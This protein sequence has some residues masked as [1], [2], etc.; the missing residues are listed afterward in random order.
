MGHWM[1]DVNGDDYYVG[2]KIE[3][4]TSS[5]RPALVMIRNFG[6]EDNFDLLP[7]PDLWRI[8]D[9]IPALVWS[10]PTPNGEFIVEFENGN[11]EIVPPYNL[12][13]LD[14]EKEFN[15]YNWD[16]Y[17]N[18]AGTCHMKYCPESSDEE[19]YPTEVYQCSVCGNVILEGKPKYCPNCGAKVIE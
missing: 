3:K 10:N 18:N 15:Q 14:G 19:F 9:Q 12:K 7:F 4:F 5:R 16:K 1:T 17:T 13:F 8:I 6:A 11:C 2:S